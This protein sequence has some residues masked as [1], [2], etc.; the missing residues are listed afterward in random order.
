MLLVYMLSEEMKRNHKLNIYLKMPTT[1]GNWY[2]KT[3]KY[4]FKWTFV[5]RVDNGNSER[6]KMSHEKNIVRSET[7][8]GSNP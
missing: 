1:Q 8:S 5:T 4:I 7:D 3:Y 2:I 6:T